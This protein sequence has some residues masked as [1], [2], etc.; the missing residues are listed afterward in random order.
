M[1]MTSACAL[2]KQDTALYQLKTLTIHC[3][4]PCHLDVAFLLRPFFKVL[5]MIVCAVCSIA[6]AY[7]R[8]R[9]RRYMD[10][11]EADSRM[12]E[13]AAQQRHDARV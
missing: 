12:T 13:M 7:S 9:N 5:I 8:N 4:L 10:L 11:K 2:Y 1:P 3:T 6:W